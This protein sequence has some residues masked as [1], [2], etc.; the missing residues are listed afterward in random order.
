MKRDYTLSGDIRLKTTP[1]EGA[2]WVLAPI[3]AIDSST[4]SEL[5][6]GLEEFCKKN[7]EI[8]SILFDI[9]EVPYISSL[10]LGLILELLKKT[11]EK[12]AAFLLYDPQI[13]VR[14]VLEISKLDFLIAHPAKIGPEH[15]FH[16]FL[17]SEEPKRQIRRESWQK[18]YEK[19]SKELLKNRG[20]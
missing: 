20:K 16:S 19:K 4:A 7:P 12:N 9:A 14:K 6:S 1:L 3:G 2:S 15:P 11:K 5:K 13:S 18:E 10:G 17:S 8:S